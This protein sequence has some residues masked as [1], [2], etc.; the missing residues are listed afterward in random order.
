MA[1]SNPAFNNSPAF[2]ARASKAAELKAPVVNSGMTAQQLTDLYSQPSANAVDT[3][4]MSYEDVMIKIVASFA[5]LLVGPGR[6]SV[7]GAMGK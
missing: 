7:D 4:R 2:S 1:S 5:I 3:N 6:I